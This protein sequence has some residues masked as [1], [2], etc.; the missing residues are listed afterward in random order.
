MSTTEPQPT[1]ERV[2]TILDMEDSA[3]EFIDQDD[4]DAAEAFV[5]R[6][7]DVSTYADATLRQVM[8]LVTADL[9]YPR[10]TGEARGQEVAS[11]SQ[12]GRSVEYTASSA[13]RATGNSTHW[14]KALR[15]TNGELAEDVGEFWF[16]S[17]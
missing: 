6:Q 1:F 11:A 15:L 12:G 16:V 5:R 2:L 9:V 17:A 4:L 13:D 7:L 3:G 10:V 14:Q 8:N